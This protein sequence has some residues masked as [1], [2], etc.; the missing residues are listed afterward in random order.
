VKSNESRIDYRRDGKGTSSQPKDSQI[1]RRGG[2]ITQTTQKPRRNESG[3]R[4]YSKDEIERLQLVKRAKLLGLSLAEIKE[5][6][7]YAIDGRCSALEY[8]LLSLVKAKLGEID[9]KI[10]DLVTFRDDLQ[11]Y[12]RDLLRRLESQT[13]ERCKAPAS[14]SC[15]CI[16]EEVDGFRK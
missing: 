13:Q 3:Y 14:V 16:G 15:Q 5:L 4:I 1:L 11:R 9:Q 6:V 10:D 8:R 7:E 2:S 12:H